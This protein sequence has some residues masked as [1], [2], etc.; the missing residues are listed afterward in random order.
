MWEVG[1]RAARVKSKGDAVMGK[2][3]LEVRLCRKRTRV[4]KHVIEH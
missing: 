4:T 2:G 1:V 3:T